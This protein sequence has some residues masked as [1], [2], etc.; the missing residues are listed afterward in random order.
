M[1]RRPYRLP[2]RQVNVIGGTGFLGRLAVSALSRLPDVEVRAMGRR[3]PHVLDVTR[4]DSWSSVDGARLVVDLSDSTRVPPDDFIASCL[5]RGIS[6]LEASSDA[7]CVERLR[8]RFAGTPGSGGARLVL[9]AGIFTGLSNLLAREAAAALDAA[10]SRLTLAISSSPFSGAGASTIAL[11][12][13]ALTQRVVSYQGGRRVE[14]E[15]LRGGPAID[16]G[17]ATRPTLRA[18]FAEASMLHESL[19]AGDVEVLFSPRPRLLHA[20]FRSMPRWLA[21]SR[22]GQALLGGYFTLLRRVLLRSLPTEV[23]LYAGA[24]AGG[25]RVERRL[26]AADGMR[27]AAFAIAAMSE[28]LLDGPRRPLPDRRVLFIDELCALEPIVARARALADDP[29]LVRL[30]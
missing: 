16:F 23:E 14:E 9:G 13:S 5:E 4:P 15:R 6:V 19:G 20:S 11:M 21:V 25:R 18:P 8:A 3:G 30:S 2:M 22:L 28:S 26:V 1:P 12:L 10:P 27:A 7:P 17:A 24:E 29:S